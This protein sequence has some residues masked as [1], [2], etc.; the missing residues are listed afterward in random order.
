MP[1]VELLKVWSLEPLVAFT[2]ARM[3]SSAHHIL[4]AAGESSSCRQT[5]TPK[6]F[7]SCTSATTLSS[8]QGTFSLLLL[9]LKLT[10]NASCF[11]TSWRVLQVFLLLSRD[12]HTGYYSDDRKSQCKRNP[13]SCSSTTQ[14]LSQFLLNQSVNC[15]S[16]M[17]VWSYSWAGAFEHR[18]YSCHVCR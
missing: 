6:S 14:G 10:S 13:R 17:S 15:C 11:V 7:T 5:Q 8:L 16:N 4:P 1:A 18:L 12:L 2:E 9:R 3:P